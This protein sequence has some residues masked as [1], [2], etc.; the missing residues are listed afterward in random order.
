M[1]KTLLAAN[2][3]VDSVALFRPN[4]PVIVSTLDRDGTPHLAPFSWCK[5]VSASPPL[6][7][8]ALLSSP[9]KQHSLIN[10][11]REG[12]FVINLPG[13][14]FAPK[15]VRF[16]YRYPV[17]VRKA[18]IANCTFKPSQEL[19][20]PIVE[21]CLA[22]VECKLVE[23][24][25]TGDHT[26]LIGEV[27]AGSYL[28]R[29]YH[30]GFILDIEHYPACLHLGHRAYRDRQMHIFMDGQ[31]LMAVEIPYDLASNGLEWQEQD[32]LKPF[33][34][35]ATYSATAVRDVAIVPRATYAVSLSCPTGLVAPQGQ[36]KLYFC[37]WAEGMIYEARPGQEHS[38]F[39]D[40][41]GMP[42]GACIGPDDDLYIADMGRKTILHVHQNGDA[43]SI[44]EAN[45]NRVLHG[46][47]ACAVDCTGNVY[48]TD[49]DGMQPATATGRLFRFRKGGETQLLLDNLI[50]PRA[51][52]LS[53]DGEILY[54]GETYAKQIRR[55]RFDRNGSLSEQEIIF[56]HESGSGPVDLTVDEEGN[57]YVAIFGGGEVLLLDPDGNCL[58]TF[59]T[60]GM[61]PTSV[62]IRGQELY[63][64]D[65]ERGDVTRVA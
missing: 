30:E 53:K 43:T 4:R 28:E 41:Q 21:Q 64:S 40:S 55:M 1:S 37:D 9:R 52:A 12:E 20:V 36:D 8:L 47:L 15:L 16:S 19:R 3:L 18:G 50:F 63:V 31:G 46:P 42:C 13:Y 27:V 56:R 33:H 29:Q 11:K 60:P 61:L 62:A 17:G 45:Q 58:E 51:L 2:S 26:L 54:L 24:L 38:P 39:I 22:H 23:T 48:F 49:A 59:Q 7:T 5:P 10:I 44:L 14:E 35:S 25:V 32:A 57:L 65:M 6:V 34:A